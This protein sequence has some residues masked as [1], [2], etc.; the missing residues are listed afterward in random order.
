MEKRIAELEAE[1][2]RLRGELQQHYESKLDL[3]RVN[4]K[5]RKALKEHREMLKIGDS[6]TGN[7]D[8]AERQKVYSDFMHRE[9]LDEG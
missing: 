2:Q 9:G 1:V 8:E 6:L 4:T 5:L 7:P 3:M